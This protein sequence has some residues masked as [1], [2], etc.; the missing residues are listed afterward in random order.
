MY[1]Q[2]YSCSLVV[3]AYHGS[4]CL[5]IEFVGKS[6]DLISRYKRKSAHQH[7]GSRFKNGKDTCRS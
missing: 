6:G 1:I 4:G 5:Y 3:K 2:V 7:C